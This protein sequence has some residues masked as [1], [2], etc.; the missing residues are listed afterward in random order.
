MSE[1]NTIKVFYHPDSAL[2]K[3]QEA[4]GDRYFFLVKPKAIFGALQKEGL[5]F[6]HRTFQPFTWKDFELCHAP[7]YSAAVKTGAPRELAKA[8]QFHGVKS[9]QKPCRI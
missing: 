7:E 4:F 6:E 3:I 1:P 2:D 5:T 9:L 8:V